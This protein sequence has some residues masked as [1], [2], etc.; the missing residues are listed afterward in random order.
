MS[1]THHIAVLPGDGIGPEVMQQAYK[2]LD[3]GTS[4]LW[5]ENHHQRIRRW[6]RS[7]RQ[8]RQPIATGHRC[9]L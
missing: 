6:R 4:A 7:H 2:V 9:R 8:A 1:K 5:P 3:A